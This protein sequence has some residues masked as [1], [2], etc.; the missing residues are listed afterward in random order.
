MTLK[1]A[2]REIMEHV[3]LTAEAR[4]RISANIRS[5][6]L[7]TV[8]KA[9]RSVPLRR[10]WAA[11]AC[12][13]LLV[14]G[15]LT[16]PRYLY[17]WQTDPQHEPVQT[18]PRFTEVSSLEELETAVGF[19]LEELSGLP[20]AVT[21]VT[22]TVFGQ[23]MAEIRY[24]GEEE[25]AVFRKAA[26]GEDPSGDYTQYGDILTISAAGHQVTLKGDQG[27]YFLAIW[28]EGACT[29]SLRL[30]CPLDQTAWASLLESQG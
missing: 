3:S 12:V 2:Y 5:A 17:S 1:A 20:F 15:G 25:T 13:A 24:L 26:G 7:S 29:C 14:A 6:D 28:Q 23:E 21:D 16:L 19:E 22:Y 10:Y 9:A 27:L 18:V 11:A 30:S 8:G 4:Q